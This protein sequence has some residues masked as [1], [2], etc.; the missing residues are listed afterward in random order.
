MGGGRPQAPE[1]P[2]DEEM[3]SL[4][5]SLTDEIAAT[6]EPDYGH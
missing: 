3:D 1:G 6:D 4:I 5:A 2:R